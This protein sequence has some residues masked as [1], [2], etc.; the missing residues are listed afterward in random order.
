MGPLANKPLNMSRAIKS[1]LKGLRIITLIVMQIY[2]WPSRV[3]LKDSDYLLCKFMQYY[4]KKSQPE[5]PDLITQK[6]YLRMVLR[7]VLTEMDQERSKI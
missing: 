1:N 5:A 4:F 6:Q 2:G 7:P 3:T